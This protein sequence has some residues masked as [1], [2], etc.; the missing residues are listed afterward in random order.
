MSIN[1]TY[2]TNY[3]KA[4]VG[5]TAQLAQ[6][7]TI[8][9]PAAVVLQSPANGAVLTNW[10]PIFRWKVTANATNYYLLVNNS[11]AKA[12]IQQWYTLSGAHCNSTTCWAASPKILSKGPYRWYVKARNSGVDGPLGSG[13][14]LNTPSVPGKV[15]LISPTSVTT[16]TPP[17]RW[18]STSRAI[19][20][21]ISVKISSGSTTNIWVASTTAGCSSGGVCTYTHTQSF[22]KGTY[23]WSIT[24]WNPSGSGIQSNP[25]N[26]TIR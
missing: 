8:P 11:L 9:A 5:T 13:F 24:A 7:A 1:L 23:T 16:T 17:F 4:S 6:V 19:R 20:Y 10:N 3:I 21:L 15:T 12:Y 26:I 22:A 14:S 25:L 2:L 18:N